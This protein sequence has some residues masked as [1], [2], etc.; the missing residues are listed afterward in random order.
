MKAGVLSKIAMQV[1]DYFKKAFDLSQTNQHLKAFDG[2]KFANIM[3][4]H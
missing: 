1:A 2:G 3:N 4:Y